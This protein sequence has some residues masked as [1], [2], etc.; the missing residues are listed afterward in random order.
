MTQRDQV[1]R[2]FGGHDPGQPGDFEHVAF[3]HLPVTNQL[4]R[5]RLH[6]D[7]GLSPSHALRDFLVANIH[8][9]AGA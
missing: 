3:R 2:L 5:F 4:K 8:H 9:T 7:D 1:L 6:R